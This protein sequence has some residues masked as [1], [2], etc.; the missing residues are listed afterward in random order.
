MTAIMVEYFQNTVEDNEGLL[1]E[2]ESLTNNGFH[3]L[4]VAVK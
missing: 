4:T 2:K 3:P 1:N